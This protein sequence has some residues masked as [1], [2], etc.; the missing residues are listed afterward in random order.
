M[1]NKLSGSS[2]PLCNPSCQTCDN[3]TNNLNIPIDGDS[4]EFQTGISTIKNL[5]KID[6]SSND[7]DF[8]Q[9]GGAGSHFQ[10][11]EISYSR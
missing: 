1:G 9:D 6:S 7:G 8:D 5:V 11:L 4:N 2:F 3:D 10:T